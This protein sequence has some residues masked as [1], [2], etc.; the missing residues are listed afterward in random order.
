MLPNILFCFL[1]QRTELIDVSRYLR[2][3]CVYILTKTHVATGAYIQKTFEQ[4][5]QCGLSEALPP[6]KKQ[7]NKNEN[8]HAGVSRVISKIESA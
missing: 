6:V 2:T 8:L 4:R 1:T 5:G 3:L 7:L